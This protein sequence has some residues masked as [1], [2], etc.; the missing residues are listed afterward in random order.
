RALVYGA[1]LNPV[2]IQKPAQQ[3]EKKGHQDHDKAE[4]NKIL[5][6]IPQ[7]PDADVLLH[8]LLVQPRHGDH[9]E[10]AADDLFEKKPLAAPIHVEYPGV[11]AAAQ[12]LPGARYRCSGMLQ[13]EYDTDH[14]AQQHEGGLQRVGI[15][16]GP[17][18]ALEGIQQDHHQD[19]QRGHPK[20]NAH[21]PKDRNI[22]DIDHEV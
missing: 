1:L 22:K 17:H 20:R 3:Q 2:L 15:D 19:H 21:I 14:Q 8:H 9:D 7:V 6:G 13:D 16:D 18:A 12:S 10:H 4:R 11:S 5:L